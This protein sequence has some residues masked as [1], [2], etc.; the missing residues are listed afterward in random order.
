MNFFD[1]ARYWWI[2]LGYN[3]LKRTSSLDVGVLWS[4]AVCIGDWE[5]LRLV[6]GALL[7]A[8]RLDHRLDYL[9]HLAFGVT[10]VLTLVHCQCTSSTTKT[11]TFWSKLAAIALLAEEVTT[12]LCGICAVQS[13]VAETTLEAL[14][15]PFGTSGQHLFGSIDRLAALWALGLLWHFKRHFGILLLVYC[16]CCPWLW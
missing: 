6:G 10:Q 15:V 13:F 11:V 3:Q 14:L 8:C 4:V 1:W 16:D 2:K 12:V 9:R 7:G 5:S